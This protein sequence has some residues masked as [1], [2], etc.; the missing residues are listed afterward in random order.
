M[1]RNSRTYTGAALLVAWMSIPAIMHAQTGAAERSLMNRVGLELRSQARE[2][3]PAATRGPGDQS[4]APRA[5][6]G[7]VGTIRF[8][9]WETGAADSGFQTPEQALLGRPGR[10]KTRNE[11]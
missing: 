3:G 5:L 6:L 1:S 9:G 4:Q 11:D 10:A 7:T 2:Q 8:A